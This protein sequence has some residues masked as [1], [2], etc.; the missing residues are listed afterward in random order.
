MRLVWTIVSNH[1]RDQRGRPHPAPGT[2]RYQRAGQSPTPPLT[3]PR[4]QDGARWFQPEPPIGGTHDKGQEE[5]AQRQAKPWTLA[6]R[7][8]VEEPDEPT[9]LTSGFV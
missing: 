9:W 7:S 6:P 8:T 1:G 2:A 3:L 5:S 4:C